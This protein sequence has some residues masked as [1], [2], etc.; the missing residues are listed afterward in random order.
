MQGHARSCKVMQGRARSCKVVQGR[1]NMQNRG[2]AKSCKVVQGRA[3]SC[4]AGRAK[5][6]DF[7][8]KL[9]SEVDPV[10]KKMLER[11][12]GLREG[13]VRSQSEL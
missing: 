11:T 13:A 4:K 3:R 6:C 7:G 9:A 8:T 1:A 5:S 2:R 10:S 12:S